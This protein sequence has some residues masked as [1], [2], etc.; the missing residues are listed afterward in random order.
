MKPQRLPELAGDTWL[1]SPPLRGEEL[2]GKVVMVNLWAFT[3]TRSLRDLRYLRRWWHD[4][5]EK[6]LVMV[7]VH[8]PEF[9]FAKDPELVAAMVRELG[10][11]WPVVLD[12]HGDIR[13]AFAAH[14]LPVEYLANREGRIVSIRRGDGGFERAEENVRR[15]L[16]IPAPRMEPSIVDLGELSRG[17]PCFVPT[18]DLYIGY[19]KG[20]IANAEGY[21][22]DREAEYTAPERLEEGSIAL[23][24]RC[25]ATPQ[26]VEATEGA[27]IRVAFN[28]TEVNLVLLP[29]GGEAVA[30]VRLG[31]EL[32]AGDVR[33]LDVAGTGEVVV[34]RPSAYNLMKADEPVR[35]ELRVEAKRGSLKAY[36]FTFS[37]CVD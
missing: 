14:E 18:P 26:Y 19:E 17:G 35:G 25:I 29:P 22:R 23:S 2:A 9:D 28:A 32:P 34:G 36:V 5:R 7:G 6:G 8:S 30:E 15:L 21:V 27:A 20:S 4:Y 3:C 37:G 16:R 12:D 24:G 33:G 11:E 13:E 10:V 31:G 1:N